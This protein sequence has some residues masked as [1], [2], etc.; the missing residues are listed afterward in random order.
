MNATARE[1]KAA[2]TFVRALLELIDAVEEGRTA[3]HP[4]SK[5]PEPVP[6]SVPRRCRCAGAEPPPLLTPREAA[7]YLRVSTG[8]V[9][10]MSAPRG[11]LPVVRIGAS[12]RYSVQDLDAAIDRMK[13]KAGGSR[14]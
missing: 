3:R 6:E 4:P 12:V 8:T 9:F 11:A 7:A 2:S 5:P 1:A 10:N 13:V 14:A